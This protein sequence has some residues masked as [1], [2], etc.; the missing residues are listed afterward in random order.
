MEILRGELNAFK[1]SAVVTE[2]L[3]IGRGDKVY[4]DK[5]TKVISYIKMLFFVSFKDISKRWSES[6]SN[7]F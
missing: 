2:Y 3:G 6:S 4:R 7:N 5:V 1:C